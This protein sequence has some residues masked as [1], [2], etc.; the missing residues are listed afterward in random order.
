VNREDPPFDMVCAM[1]PEITTPAA[2]PA[3]SRKLNS[4]KNLLFSLY[5]ESK[6]C[7]VREK[8]A[9]HAVH[10]YQSCKGEPIG[11]FQSQ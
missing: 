10:S 1:Y 11:V 7:A 4:P 9:P 3:L 6:E 8:K 5:S 2:K